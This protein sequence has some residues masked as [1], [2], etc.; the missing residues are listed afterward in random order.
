MKK[1]NWRRANKGRRPGKATRAPALLIRSVSVK[2]KMA[3]RRYATMRQ[4]TLAQYLMKLVDLHGTMLAVARDASDDE[5]QRIK[6][7]LE[8][9]GLGPVEG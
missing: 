6:A 5:H 4:L 9:H 8:A 1:P 7:M 3:M 2:D